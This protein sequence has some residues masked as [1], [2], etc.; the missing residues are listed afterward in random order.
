MV[1]W[2]CKV[3]E[4]SFRLDSGRFRTDQLRMQ[5]KKYRALIADDHEVQIADMNTFR[6][7][8]PLGEII[9]GFFP[10]IIGI[11]LRNIDNTDATDPRGFIEIYRDLF[12]SLKDIYYRLSN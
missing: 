11:S 7:N 9:R 12:G 6:D 2:F 3:T 1:W 4:R 10:D 5:T 8:E